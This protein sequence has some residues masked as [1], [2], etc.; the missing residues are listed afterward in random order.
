MAQ[1]INIKVTSPGVCSGPCD[2]YSDADG[3]TTA[4]ATGI[5]ITVLSSIIGYNTTSVPPG[6][7]TIRIQNDNANC[8]NFV[9]VPITT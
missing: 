3:Y 2:L 9:D 1:T 7:T 8:S 6:A 5:S 4:F